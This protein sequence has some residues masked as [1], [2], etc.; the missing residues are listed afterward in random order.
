MPDGIQALTK[1]QF[2]KEAGP[3]PALL[4]P[5][6]CAAYAPAQPEV[7]PVPL[8]GTLYE[9]TGDSNV[10]RHDVSS[11]GQ[12][13]GGDSP[14]WLAI[15]ERACLDLMIADPPYNLKKAE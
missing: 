15:L 6:P 9:V 2:S 11:H 8:R 3:A 10:P 5:R 14:A 12:L 4:D 7:L 13:Y 1:L